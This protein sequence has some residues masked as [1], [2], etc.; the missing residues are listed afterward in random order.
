MKISKGTVYKKKN[1]PYLYINI[2]INQKRY[3][4]NTKFT[5][6][7]ENYVVKVELPLLKAKLISGEIVL[8][9]EEF[10]NKTFQ[11]YSDVFLNGK[12][13]LKHST[14]KRYDS[15]LNKINLT[16]GSRI[17]KEI[18][19]SEIKSYLFRMD[20]KPLTLRNYLII[21]RG[22][23]DEA[24]I[25]DELSS[26]PCNKVQLPKNQVVDIEPFSID[27][28]NI[29]LDGASGWLKNFLAT[30]FYTG[31]RTGELFAMKWQ[32][33][34]LKNK[35]IYIDATRSEHYKE[36]SP[37]NGKNRYVPIFNSLVP[38][39]KEQKKVTGLKTYVFLTERGKL[40]NGS[41]LIK[42]HWY[43]LL[44][45]LKLP[46]KVVYNTRHTFATNMITS[47]EF[48]LN[49]IASW[50]GHSNIRML[51]MHYNKFISSELDK[52]DSNFDVFSTKKC[53]THS[54]TA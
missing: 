4:I 14:F 35:R 10:I 32:N 23:F 46:R 16:F 33:I 25:D 30:A 17:I 7:K 38:Y 5:H 34:D 20:I 12:K 1:S 36:G 47:N 53:D 8:N 21:F 19:A 48:S 26:N 44:K 24:L 27:E 51:V 6:D 42:Y 45:R 9:N 13:F 50:L 49:Q 3:F 22:V 31:A 11:H 18:K 2:S 39:L 54:A 28:V 15:T 41:N 37:K 52:F 40:L 29:I 43:P